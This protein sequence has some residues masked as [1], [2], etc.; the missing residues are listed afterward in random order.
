MLHAVVDFDE[1]LLRARWRGESGELL[2]I[3]I[4]DSDNDLVLRLQWNPALQ[5]PLKS[6]H[7]DYVD[8][9]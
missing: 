2:L 7:L 8:T 6:G 9:F 5:T 4:K 3:I 1:I